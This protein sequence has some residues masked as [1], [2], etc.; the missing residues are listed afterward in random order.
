MA[1]KEEINYAVELFHKNR[2]QNI[3]KEMGEK[4]KGILAV[5]DYLSTHDGEVKSKD[6]SESMHISSARMAVLL[7]TME[8][9]GLIVKSNSVQDRRATIVSLSQKGKEHILF[10]ERQFKEATGQIIDEFGMEKLISLFEDFGKIRTIMRS[11][12]KGVKEK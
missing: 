8:K 11:T 12:M 5:L 1:T 10:F 4:D 3:F 6:I 7:K 2:P 9:K